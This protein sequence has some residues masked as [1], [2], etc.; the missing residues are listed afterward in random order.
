MK[1]D[2]VNKKW[3]GTGRSF[4]DSFVTATTAPEKLIPAGGQRYVKARR[5]E[6]TRIL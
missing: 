6:W 4:N 3:R 5:P 2:N 1:K